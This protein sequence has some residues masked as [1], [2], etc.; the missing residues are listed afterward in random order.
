MVA[1]LVMD[2]YHPVTEE[3]VVEENIRAITGGGGSTPIP[4]PPERVLY[5]IPIELAYAQLLERHVDPGGLESYNARMIG[6]PAAG[7]MTEAEMREHLIRSDEYNRK[8]GGA[9]VRTGIV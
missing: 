4:P 7:Q 6:G 3:T 1:C 5:R 9:P 2:G 8:N